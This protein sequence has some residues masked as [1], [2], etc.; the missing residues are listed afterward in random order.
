[1]TRYTRRTAVRVAIEP[2]YAQPPSSWDPTDVI[3][4][5]ALPKFR[6]DRD[7]VP[8]DLVR[9]FLG[10]SEQ[11]IGTRRAILEFEVEL[12]GSG[13]ANVPPAYGRLLRICGMA[14]TVV[15]TTHVTYNPITDG[16]ESGTIEFFSDGVRYIGRGARG[17][18]RFRLNAYSIPTV[19]F[20]IWAF[21]VNAVEASVPTGNFQNW[22]TPIV[23]ADHNS[24]DIRIGA[25][26]TAATGVVG[27]GTVLRSRG[28]EWD[29]GHTVSHAKLLGGEAIHLPQRETTGRMTVELTAAQEIAWRNEINNN[30]L[31]SIGFTIGPAAGQ[32]VSLFAPAV[33]RVDPQIEDYEGI[34]LMTVEL[35]FL[36]TGSSGNNEIRLITR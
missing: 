16:H 7:L 15:G 36:P 35:R 32:I 21:D 6:I 30:A 17:T 27:G 25:T 20:T 18:A 24:A 2:S 11:L 19:Q 29:L 12:A 4:V 22:Q 23:I 33:Q 26:Y 8:R 9:P 10:G 5:R 31:T 28:M 3:L 34:T 1:M 14:E 13:T